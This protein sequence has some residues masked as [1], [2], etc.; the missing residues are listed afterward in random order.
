[1]PTASFKGTC[2]L[3]DTPIDRRRALAHLGTCAPA[4][5]NPKDREGELLTLRVG[6]VGTTAYWLFVEA[7]AGKPLSK[8]DAFLRGIWLEC[9][10]HLSMFSVSGLRYSTAPSDLPRLLG[11]PNVERSMASKVAVVFSQDGTK[12]TYEYDFG[13]TTELS[14]ERVSTRVGRV[15]K[16]AV[17]LLARNDPIKWTCGVCGALATL[18]CCVHETADSPFA[19]DTHAPDHGCG[20][21]AFLPVVNSPRMGICGYGG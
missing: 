4:H 3:C 12:G 9:C 11:R 16:V 15:S 13:S 18:V 14:I 2:A 8:L 10:G 6:A 7:D 20:D 1:M 19:C 21:E 17:R 5:D